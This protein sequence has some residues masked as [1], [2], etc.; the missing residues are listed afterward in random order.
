MNV[1]F[2]IF[3]IL[4]YK[5]KSWGWFYKPQVSQG[6]LQDKDNIGA[7]FLTD[8]DSI[9]SSSMP[10]TMKEKD[11]VAAV[12]VVPQQEEDMPFPRPV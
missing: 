2:A 8:N 11:I 7:E 6:I 12:V 10:Q 3:L 5:V 9:I 4:L 1:T